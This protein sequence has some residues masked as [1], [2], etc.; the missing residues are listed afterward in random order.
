MCCRVV[1]ECHAHHTTYHTQG[2]QDS[3]CWVQKFNF[4]PWFQ[5]CLLIKQL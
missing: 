3:T 2:T 4:Y 5:D 1:M